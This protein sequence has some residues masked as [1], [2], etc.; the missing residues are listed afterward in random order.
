MAKPVKVP[1]KTLVS[2]VRK[3]SGVAKHAAEE[4]GIST[5]TLLIKMRELGYQRVIQ[6][7]KP[8]QKGSQ[9]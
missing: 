7:Q 6:W 4:L 9:P 8:E 1:E 5:S 2:T 3:H